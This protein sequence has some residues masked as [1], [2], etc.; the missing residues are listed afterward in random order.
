MPIVDAD[1]YI[2]VILVG[3]PDDAYWEKVEKEAIRNMREIQPLIGSS[4]DDHTHRR[5]TFTSLRCGFSYG[6]GQKKP[7][8]FTPKNLSE[9]RCV[10]H[11]NSRNCFQRIASFGSCKPIIFR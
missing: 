2:V 7:Q 10:E 9:A 4:N 8:N 6:G 1:G 11:L 5:G 3:H